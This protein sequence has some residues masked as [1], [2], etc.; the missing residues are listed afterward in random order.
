V[1]ISSS[2]G[3]CTGNATDELVV[4]SGVTVVMEGQSQ[5]RQ[6]LLCVYSTLVNYGLIEGGSFCDYG[7]VINYGRITVPK[8]GFFETLPFNGQ[9]ILDN[10]NGGEIVN[11]YNF[12]DAGT[13][14]NNG[15]IYNNGQF[16]NDN[17]YRGNFTNV[18]T[19]VGSAPCFG[20]NGCITW[21]GTYNITSSGTAIYQFN[22]GL[23]VNFTGASGTNVAVISQNQTTSAPFG[24]GSISVASAVYYDVMVN[25]LS[26][27]T[28]RICVANGHV[29]RSMK[30][31]MEYWNGSSWAFAQSQTLSESVRTMTTDANQSMTTSPSLAFI[32]CGD[33][34]V[35]S[36]SGTPLGTGTPTTVYHSTS[37]RTSMEG[38]TATESP[39][40][41]GGG[42]TLNSTLYVGTGVVLI[43]ALALMV[44]RRR[45]ISRGQ[46]R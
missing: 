6:A 11:D 31:G 19:F 1:C 45:S 26:N 2:P 15:T 9:G 27:G 21:I 43:V 30:G 36:L 10:R 16:G 34:P 41:G 14:I 7:T 8:G 42:S 35:A 29:D 12:V 33:I 17:Q 46:T 28:A 23:I 38:S 4:D 24:L 22:G 5:L 25:G 40:E 37:T 32:L 44:M 18:G 39:A 13:I 20:Y 3:G